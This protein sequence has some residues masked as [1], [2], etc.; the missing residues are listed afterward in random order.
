MEVSQEWE[1]QSPVGDGPNQLTVALIHTPT[2]NL[3][4]STPWLSLNEG[5]MHNNVYEREIYPCL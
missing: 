3:H 4:S 1:D 2:G 5:E